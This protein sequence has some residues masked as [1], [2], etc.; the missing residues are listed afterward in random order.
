MDEEVP[1]FRP[2][3]IEEVQKLDEFLKR[4][5]EGKESSKY[6]FKSVVLGKMQFTKW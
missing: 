2:H 4:L 6:T 3:H 5:S 1:S